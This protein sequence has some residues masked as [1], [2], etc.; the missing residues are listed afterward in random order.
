M[1]VPKLFL[2]DR[3]KNKLLDVYINEKLSNTAVDPQGR[4]W[5]SGLYFKKQ[6]EENFPVGKLQ[7]L[8]G[9]IKNK[10][11]LSKANKKN[12]LQIPFCPN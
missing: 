9:G 10:W 2:Y 1:D 6:L 11:R 3:Q 8:L 4:I 5:L 7:K 12:S